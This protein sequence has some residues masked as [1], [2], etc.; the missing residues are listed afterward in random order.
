MFL[1]EY[2][3]SGS[4]QERS[5]EAADAEILDGASLDIYIS[6]ALS[7]ERGMS[8]FLSPLSD[9]HPSAPPLGV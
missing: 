8:T 5:F 4:K 7:S 3:L 2:K 6:I 9:V 1:G